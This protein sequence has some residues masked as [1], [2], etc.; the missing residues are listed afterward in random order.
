MADALRCSAGAAMSWTLCLEWGSVK[1]RVVLVVTARK[2]SVFGWPLGSD[3][4]SF[5]WVLQ[6]AGT[7]ELADRLVEL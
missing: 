7:V 6:H 4:G 1:S 5:V 3:A 2:S